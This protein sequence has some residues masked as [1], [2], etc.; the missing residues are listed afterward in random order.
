MTS[1]LQALRAAAEL[2]G[3][4]KKQLRS[5]LPYVDEVTVPAGRP[6]AVKGRPCNQFV[7]LAEGRLRSG[8]PGNG[9]H[10]LAPGDSFGWTA[11]WE[12]TENDAT[13]VAETEARLLVMGHAQ[14]R[15]IKGVAARPA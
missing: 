1:R 3:C 12:R 5:L 6:I 15:A 7:I 4:S 2:A 10:S 11:M 14:F 8:T 9:Q 13:L